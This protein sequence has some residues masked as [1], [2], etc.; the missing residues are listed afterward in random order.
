MATTS[1]ETINGHRY[2]VIRD[3]EGNILSQLAADIIV[4]PPVAL[5][6]FS[7]L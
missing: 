4:P 2:E 1:F 3:D 5:S 7:A 6:K